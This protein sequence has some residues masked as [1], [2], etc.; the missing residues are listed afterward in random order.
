MSEPNLPYFTN[1]IFHENLRGD[2]LIQHT[3]N[4]Q[5]TIFFTDYEICSEKLEN[6]PK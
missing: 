3:D 4:Q 2:N 1:I 6:S 5:I